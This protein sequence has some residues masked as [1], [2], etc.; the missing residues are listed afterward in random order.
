MIVLSNEE[1]VLG[2]FDNIN[3]L[4]DFA[5]SYCIVIDGSV[6]FYHEDESY[7]LTFLKLNSKEL[8]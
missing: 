1:V 4:P 6:S 8:I 3:K 7:T 5:V 2:V